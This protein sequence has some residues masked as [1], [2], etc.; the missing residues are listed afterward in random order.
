MAEIKEAY[1]T[2]HNRMELLPY[3]IYNVY[4]TLCNVRHIYSSP[5]ICVINH[6]KHTNNKV[7]RHDL[8]FIR[9]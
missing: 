2:D 4:C 6:Y 7:R 9:R 3:W 8:M 1:N 5:K